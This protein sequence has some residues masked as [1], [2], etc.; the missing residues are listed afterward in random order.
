MSNPLKC[1]ILN[2]YFAYNF[3]SINRVIFFRRNSV[4]LIINNNNSKYNADNK[5]NNKKRTLP[6][7]S[8]SAAALVIAVAKF[9]LSRRPGLLSTAW[10]RASRCVLLRVPIHLVSRIYGVCWESICKDNEAQAGAFDS[11][12]VVLRA[13]VYSCKV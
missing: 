7:S 4:I 11:A 12:I 1:L 2:R 9:N 3:L 13:A 6:R 8:G 5:R 10:S